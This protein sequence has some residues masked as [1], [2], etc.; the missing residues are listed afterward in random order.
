MASVRNLIFIVHDIG[1]MSEYNFQ[2]SKWKDFSFDRENA[3]NLD[4]DEIFAKIRSTTKLNKIK[5]MV[6]TIFDMRFPGLFDAFE[7]RAKCLEFCKSNGILYFYIPMNAMIPFS[8]MAKAKVMV[9]EGEYVLTVSPSTMYQKV[10]TNLLL[11]KKDYYQFVSYQV[12]YDLS[13]TK[14]W[15]EKWMQGIKPKKVALM[16]LTPLDSRQLLEQCASL[17]EGAVVV[18]ET[19]HVTNFSDAIIEKVLHVMGDKISPYDV[20]IQCQNRTVVF[21]D[22][23][24]LI[25]VEWIAALPLEESVIIDVDPTK[26]LMLVASCQSPKNVPTI[27][28][29]IPL[30]GIATKKAKVTLKI[31]TN[32]FHEVE[33]H[34]IDGD[35]VNEKLPKNNIVDFEVEKV[36]L[37]FDKQNFVVFGRND[38][39]EE[40]IR[41]ANGADKTPIYIAFTEKKPVFGKTAMDVYGHKPNLVVFDLIKLCSISN[42]DI[43]NPKWGFRLEKEEN[44]SIMVTIETVEGERRSSV[45]FLLA[46]ILKHGLE[47]IK[48]GIGKKMGQIEIGFV[49]GFSPNEILKKNFIEAGKLIKTDIVFV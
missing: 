29:E 39:K 28:D 3:D 22:N 24:P 6:F 5:A 49:D 4:A 45:E 30:T 33:V 11:R 14:Q 17:F 26:V 35:T 31:D 23:S 12:I 41:T 36:R 47:I 44:E 15:K 42:A 7:F 21:M 18:R 43:M 16:N 20:T 1:E 9:D 27:F 25:T 2:T 8:V 38:D 34:Q 48:N 10:Y 46:L 32:S 19:S 13:I 40:I 37:V